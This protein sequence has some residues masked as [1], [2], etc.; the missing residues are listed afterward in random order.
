MCTNLNLKIDARNPHHQMSVAR[1]TVS[2]NQA[3]VLNSGAIV[4]QHAVHIIHHAV[5][6]GLTVHDLCVDAT[7]AGLMP[8]E[9]L[10]ESWLRLA[11]S[12][13]ED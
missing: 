7:I 10:S 3:H 9:L 8:S 2:E 11:A 5:I 6:S 13:R 1:V 12:A 4:V